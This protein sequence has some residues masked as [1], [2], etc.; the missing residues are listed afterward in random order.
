MNLLGTV[1]GVALGVVA[2]ALIVMIGWNLG[3]VGIVGALGGH[4]AGINFFTAVGLLIV[5][6][7]LSAAF[8]P[9]ISVE[10]NPKK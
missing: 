10:V 4:A 8:K 7:L 3:V 1:I 6:A 5:L 9:D 2:V